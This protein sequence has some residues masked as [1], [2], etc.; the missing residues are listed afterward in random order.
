[1][2]IEF[3]S[4]FA[5]LGQVRAAVAAAP[6]ER[7]LWGSDVPLLDPT[8]VY[9]TYEDA[10]IRREDWQRVFWANSAELYGGD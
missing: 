10:G 1:V 7:I 4:S 2:Y 5:K 6:V 3:S 9:G 8:Y